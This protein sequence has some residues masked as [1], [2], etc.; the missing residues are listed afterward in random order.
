[1]K[2]SPSILLF[3][4]LQ[5]PNNTYDSIYLSN[6]AL[7]NMVETLKRV[8]G[9]GDAMIFGAKDYSIRVWLDPSKLSKYSLAT[10]DVIAVIKEQ[11]NQY[12]AGKLQLNQLQ[13]KQMYTY[14]IQTPERFDDPVQFANI[15][16]R[17]NPDGSSLKLKDVATIELGASNYSMQTRL[18]NAPSLPIGVFLQSEANALESAAAIKKH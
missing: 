9:V 13:N 11:N 1:M 8:E 16:I 4:M 2:K 7:L 18:N 3:A 14:T 6:Y 15:V 17:S 10:T 5:S 12:A